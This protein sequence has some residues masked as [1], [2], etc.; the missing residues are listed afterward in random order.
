MTNENLEYY[1]DSYEIGYEKIID[2]YAVANS[3]TRPVVDLLLPR[4]RNHPRYQS[5]AQIS[6]MAAGI[7]TIYCPSASDGLEGTEVEGRVSR[8][9]A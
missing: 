5:G 8:M 3:S 4:Y 9:S 2:T 1:Q 7:K 6:C